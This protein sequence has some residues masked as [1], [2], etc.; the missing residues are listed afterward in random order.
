MPMLLVGVFQLTTMKFVNCTHDIYRMWLFLMFL[1]SFFIPCSNSFCLVLP[2]STG[3]SEGDIHS[4]EW[5]K[6]DHDFGL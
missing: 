3:G 4:T 5:R 6:C 1:P 2:D